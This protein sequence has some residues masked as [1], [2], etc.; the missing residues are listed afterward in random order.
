M[1]GEDAVGQGPLADQR[2]GADLRQVTGR[3]S[4]P[5]KRRNQN[6]TESKP[7]EFTSHYDETVPLNDLRMLMC[8]MFCFH[9]SSSF[10]FC[11]HR[12]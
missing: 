12:M 1:Q 4:T 9:S 11:C 10:L 8:N 3:D 5:K 2:G 6:K 7:A